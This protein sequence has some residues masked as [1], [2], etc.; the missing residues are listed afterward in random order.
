MLPGGVKFDIARSR[1]EVSIESL[2]STRDSTPV[3]IHAEPHP[4]HSCVRI[5][6]TSLLDTA[7]SAR[8]SCADKRNDGPSES[9][10]VFYVARG[11][12]S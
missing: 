5:S 11:T 7:R 8:L 10:G 6:C 9:F 3:K 4:H 2:T 1:L 12:L